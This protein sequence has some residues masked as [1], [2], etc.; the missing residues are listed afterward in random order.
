[1]VPAAAAAAAREEV[2][3]AA[4][5]GAAGVFCGGWAAHEG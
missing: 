2:V 3:A 4:Y 1:L 5:D